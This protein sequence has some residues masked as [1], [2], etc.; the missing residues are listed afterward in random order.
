ML[1]LQLI[2]ARVLDGSPHPGTA[3]LD[4]ASAIL[5]ALAD[6]GCVVDLQEVIDASL[7]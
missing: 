4:T 6:A 7:Q 3:A 2:I 5:E 1:D